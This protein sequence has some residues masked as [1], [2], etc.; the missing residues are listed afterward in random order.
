MNEEAVKEAERTSENYTR[1]QEDYEAALLNM[2]Q[3]AQENR[4]RASELKVR[5]DALR[6]HRRAIGKLLSSIAADNLR[7]LDGFHISIGHQTVYRA[8]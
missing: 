1:L 3:L 6:Q 4:Q 7:I 2:D 5:R 8:R